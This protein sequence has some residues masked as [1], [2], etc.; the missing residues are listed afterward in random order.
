[1]KP[2][3]FASSSAFCR[4]LEKHHHDTQE[5]WVG[6]H[7]KGSG[8]PSI[9]W[10]EAVDAA[11]CF[12]WI[13]GVRRRVDAQSYTIR[14]TPRRPSSVWSAVNL[15]RMEA[16]TGMGVVQS[17]GLKAWQERNREKSGLYSYEQRKSAKLSEEEEKR[18]KASKKAWDFFRAQA[19][20][21]QRTAVFWVISAKKE[22][23]RQKRLARLIDASGNEQ[24]IAPLKRAK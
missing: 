1:M 11:L 13:D 3:F 6:L 7:K 10:P 16:L 9:T 5:L 17:P 22:E 24:S 4:W 19:P 12:G 8:K 20:W 15:T 14:F 23:T 18:F 21:Y 2:V